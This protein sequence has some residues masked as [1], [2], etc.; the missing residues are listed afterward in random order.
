MSQIPVILYGNKDFFAVTGAPDWSGG[1]FDGK[2]RVP[3]GGLQAMTPEL[4]GVLYHEYAH[5][6][7]A[8]KGGR[9]VPLWF[10]EG[11]AQAAQAL[12]VPPGNA[13]G[14]RVLPFRQLER[15]FADLPPDEV[16]L[17]YAQ[18]YAFVAFL[19]ERCGWDQVGGTLEKLGAGMSMPQAFAAAAGSCAEPLADIEAHWLAGVAR[20]A[21]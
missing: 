18:S 13:I 8:I 21:D 2:I 14:S 19:G 10:N 11:L 20:G 6:L 1:L 9:N 7:I 16:R 17:A 4:A 12:V 3:V 5:V 15:S